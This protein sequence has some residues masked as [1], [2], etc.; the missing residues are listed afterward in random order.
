MV[1]KHFCSFGPAPS[2]TLQAL[3]RISIDFEYAPKPTLPSFL[4]VE[5]WSP[6]MNFKKRAD[7]TN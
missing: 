1:S 5:C 2:S 4:H 3:T 6:I 7:K